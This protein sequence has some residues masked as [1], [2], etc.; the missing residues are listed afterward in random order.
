M[1][2]PVQPWPDRKGFGAELNSRKRSAQLL[3]SRFAVA[4]D[5]LRSS[6]ITARV[7][8]DAAFGAVTGFST[9]MLDG[10]AELPSNKVDPRQLSLFAAAG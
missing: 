7:A 5:Q 10:L 3:R 6:I 9:Y 4:R 1:L 8:A 2:P